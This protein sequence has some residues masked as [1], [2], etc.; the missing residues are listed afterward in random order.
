MA[1]IA[2]ADHADYE[3][4]IA[5]TTSTPDASIG[6]VIPLTGFAKWNRKIENLAGIEARGITRVPSNEREAATT[7]HYA[8]MALIWFSANL[9]ANNLALGLLGP[10]VFE[11][12]FTD[13]A[14]CACFGALIGSVLTSYM[15]IWGA[16]SG[17]RTLVRADKLQVT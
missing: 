17:N 8:Q 15:S 16:Q 13:S 10:L 3:K 5:A 7:A 11:L 14:L 6:E 12:G 9:T 1:T 4:N 2:S